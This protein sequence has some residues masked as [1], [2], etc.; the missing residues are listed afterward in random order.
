LGG[1]GGG[2]DLHGAKII[3]G[4]VDVHTHGNSGCDFSDGDEAG[5]RTMAAYEG[6]NGVTSFLPT[7]MTLPYEVLAKAFANARTVADSPAPG[8]ARVMGID[9]EGPFCSEKKKGAQNPAY[10]KNP[11]VAAFRKLNESCGGLVKIVVVAP[12]LSGGEEFIREIS[13][14]C[15]VSIAHTD[16][17]Y[18]QAV[19]GIEAG[20]SHLTHLY[21]AMASLHHRDPGPIA[22]CAESENVMAELICDGVHIHPAAV[23][24]AFKLFPG[25]ICLI[26]DSMRACGMPEG[27]SDLGGQKVYIQGR[28]ATL[29]DGTIAGSATNLYDCMRTAVSFGIGE[30]EAILA[31]TWNPARSAGLENQVGA[32]APGLYAD[33][34]VCDEDLTAKQVYIGGK[35]V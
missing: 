14:D 21:N 31:A 24:A 32:I 7:S 20:A 33:F 6:K 30:T 16:C 29:A 8:A 15:V 1:H 22:A 26:S 2:V 5:L 10:L 34:V 28:K 13:K 19:L 9:M 12:E 3:P 27:E 25:R 18:D 23:R 35:P 11:D 4:L 17:D